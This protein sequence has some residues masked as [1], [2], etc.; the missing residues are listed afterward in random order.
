MAGWRRVR[1]SLGFSCPAAVMEADQRR[2]ADVGPALP[3]AL[4][5]V[6]SVTASPAACIRECYTTG[7]CNTLPP[8]RRTD[9][10]GRGRSSRRANAA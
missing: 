10:V 6:R 3:W 9:S 8:G 1:A 4:G 2:S 5:T 7:G